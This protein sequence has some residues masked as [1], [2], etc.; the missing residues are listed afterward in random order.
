M[1]TPPTSLGRRVAEEMVESG[2]LERPPDGRRGWEN[3]ERAAVCRQCPM[4]GYKEPKPVRVDELDCGEIEDDRCGIVLALRLD[5]R[6]N[7]CDRE[8]VQIT[9]E[10]DPRYVG[11]A[12]H[13]GYALLELVWPGES[14]VGPRHLSSSET[15]SI[16]D[17]SSAISVPRN[18]IYEK[19]VLKRKSCQ[20]QALA[21]PDE[22]HP[23]A[24]LRRARPECPDARHRRD[25]GHHR[26]RGPA[27]RRRSRRGGLCDGQA[28]GPAEPLRDQSGHRDAPRGTGRASHLG[29]PRRARARLRPRHG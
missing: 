9:G 17:E 13:L 28:R 26:A 24:S 27:D 22:P 2:D 15:A 5:D 6:S 16:Y 14:S 25:G 11:I 12:N 3:D 7:P 21:V 23:G 4:G 10:H 18:R 19:F 20:W 1:P 29:A 8:H